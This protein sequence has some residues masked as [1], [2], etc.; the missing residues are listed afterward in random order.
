[1]IASVASEGRLGSGFGI[2]ELPMKVPP[3]LLNA[4]ST[5][6]ASPCAGGRRQLDDGDNQYVLN[7][8][9]TGFIPCES[10]Q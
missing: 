10:G 9:L 6:I 1:L 3:A 5:S 7:Q 4:L 2:G 8:P